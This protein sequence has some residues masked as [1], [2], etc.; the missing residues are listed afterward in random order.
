[1]SGGVA[2]GQASRR[3]QWAK[4]TPKPQT[5]ANTLIYR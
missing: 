5:L 4:W 3:G 2:W 1:V